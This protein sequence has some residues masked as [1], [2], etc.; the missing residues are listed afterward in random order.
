[1]SARL[2]LVLI[3]LSSSVAFAQTGP[4]VE[5]VQVA[6]SLARSQGARVAWDFTN[7]T[8]SRFALAEPDAALAAATPEEAARRLLEGDAGRLL[9]SGAARALVLR[10]A[11]YLGFERVRVDFEEVAGAATV[12]DSFVQVEVV[13]SGD[14]WAPV[15][16]AAH[17]TPSVPRV[18]GS[19][20]FVVRTS[21]GAFRS[22]DV[23]ME[24]D[25]ADVSRVVTDALTGAELARTR[26]DGCAQAT[27]LAWD[28][29]P[30]AG[31]QSS[32]A[33]PFLYVFQS[34]ASVTTDANGAFSLTG[35]TSLDQGLSGPYV[36]VFP[37]ATGAAPA[38]AGA[39]GSPDVILAF[40]PT[41]PRADEVACFHHAMEYRAY[42]K[43]VY[44][45]IGAAADAR[46]AFHILE[47]APMIGQY[48]PGPSTYGG[49]T[50]TGEIHL[51]SVGANA[52]D[53]DATVVRHEYTHG[54]IQGLAFLG[55]TAEAKGINEGLADYFPCV[56]QESPRVGPW[57]NPPYF[58]DLSQKFIWPRD[59]LQNEPHRIGNIFAGALW[60]ART[61]A[62][63][64]KPGDRLAVDQAVFQG[65]LR[66]GSQPSLY[67]GRLA[68][69][70]G[71]Q[72][73]N[74]GR[75]T[76]LLEQCFFEHGIGPAPSGVNQ[77]PVLAPLSDQTVVA[78]QTLTV[79]VSATDPDGDPLTLAASTVAGGSFASVAAL[80]TFTFAST[81]TGTFSVT[82]TASDGS[83]SD[84]KTIRIVVTASGGAA[85]VS[86]GSGSGG[87]TAPGASSGPS[88][89]P[90]SGGGGG[91]GGG[92]A[93]AAPGGAGPAALLPALLAVGL[94]LAARARNKIASCPRTRPGGSTSWES[95]A[96]PA[97]RGR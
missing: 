44:P 46:F 89:V 45:A 12:L 84:T 9:E 31:A 32:Y 23:R 20:A 86:G 47:P 63:A 62:E 66:M 50:F 67:E 61:R 88:S 28:P 82:F 90:F 76:T 27:G 30:G 75:L 55:G 74:G 96:R 18:A 40:G 41:D 8:A 1:M 6:E 57:A 78:G 19:G 79:S 29:N 80:G 53:R 81:Q 59:N 95:S 64:A 39:T 91:G 35:A 42:M 87:G 11:R 48:A 38:T 60:E 83:L 65:L 34:G 22:A 43:R 25:G 26:L 70:A 77:P 17:Y 13:R 85:G 37:G 5:R 51:G 58:R 93:L 52:C 7:G 49:E 16:F 71:D 97:G 69:T 21:A 72:A 73:A 94:V 4:D 24:R 10:G 36:H 68:I 14:G 56:E 3:A 92:C 33:L 54:F 2:A 15:G